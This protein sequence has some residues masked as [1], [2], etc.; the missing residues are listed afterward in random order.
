MSTRQCLASLYSCPL[1][2]LPRLLQSKQGYRA[3]SDVT[4]LCTFRLSVRNNRNA[5]IGC[6]LLRQGLEEGI[7]RGILR[8]VSFGFLLK[9]SNSH[10]LQLTGRILPSRR[11]PQPGGRDPVT[12]LKAT[13]GTRDTFLLTLSY[14]DWNVSGNFATSLLTVTV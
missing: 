10:G 12:R 2:K 8:G 11:L 13:T 7:R 14:P 9:A 3:T 6:Q 4:Y 5:L 1:S